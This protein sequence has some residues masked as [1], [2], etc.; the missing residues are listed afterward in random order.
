MLNPDTA[1]AHLNQLLE[2]LAD[3]GVNDSLKNQILTA[4]NIEAD[5]PNINEFRKGILGYFIKFLLMLFLSLPN[6]LIG[7]NH[8]ESFSSS[9]HCHII[10]SPS[11]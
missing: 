3:S 10:G 2:N 1:E 8:E 4:L 9:G 11:L 7:R 6:S 5:N